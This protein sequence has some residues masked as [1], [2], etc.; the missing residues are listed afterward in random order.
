MLKLFKVVAGG[1]PFYFETKMDAKH[2]RNMKPSNTSGAYSDSVVMRGPDHWRGESF[3]KSA[4][5]KSQK[6]DIW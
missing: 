4:V 3:N 1:T 2:Y 5:T 6:K